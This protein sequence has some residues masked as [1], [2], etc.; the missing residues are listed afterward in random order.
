MADEKNPKSAPRMG[1]PSWGGLYK[2]AIVGA[3]TLKGRE[4]KETLEEK[5]FP[6]SDIV[7]L[8]DE[9]SL[10]QLDSVG[11]EATF[12]QGITRSSF[13]NVDLVFFA[14]EEAFTR[15]NWQ[16]A[17]DAGCTLVDLSYTLEADS[18]IAIRSPWLEKELEPQLDCSA[19]LDL[20]TTSVVAA[21]P[22]AVVLALLLHRAY[23]TGAVRLAS[24]NVFEPVSEQGKK[25]MDELHHQTLNL[26][27]LQSLP[28]EM[29]DAQVSFN[30]L[31]RRGEEAK[32][33]IESAAARILKHLKLLTRSRMEMP[34]LQVIQTPTFHGYVMSIYLE[35]DRKVAAADFSLA[36]K[37]EHVEITSP[38]DEA[39][40]N[41][42]AA[43]QENV[44]VSV[45]NDA[46]REKGIWLWVAADNLKIS[47]LTAAECG[48]LLAAARPSGKIQ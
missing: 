31:T 25:G 14:S 23:T 35:L 32:I 2:I 43:G 11:E 6:A 45:R 17:K 28:K 38:D 3:A 39:P 5:N 33:T 10:G 15:A 36:L 42:S 29:Y 37:G 30:I 48:A 20:S 41:V 22:A 18:T 34:A 24:V 27:S 21:H 40:N 8:D 13:H 26:L 16:A 47:A 1:S 9:E 7:L 4:L 19:A 46:T 12:I 44:L